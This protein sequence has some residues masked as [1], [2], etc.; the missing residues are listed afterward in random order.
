MF[1]LF[2]ICQWE[3]WEFFVSYNSDEYNKYFFPS[4]KRAFLK[5]VSGSP[6]YSSVLVDKA[7]VSKLGVCCSLFTDALYTI[8][9]GGWNLTWGRGK[10]GYYENGH[11]FLDIFTKKQSLTNSHWSQWRPTSSYICCAQ[12]WTKLFNRLRKISISGEKAFR[13]FS[14]L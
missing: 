1:V 7:K 2:L 11:F 12:V 3:Y 10:T 9:S 6:S 13:L 4:L 14:V 8:W 5:N